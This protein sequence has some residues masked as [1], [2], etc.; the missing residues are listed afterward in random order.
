[1][2]RKRMTI[3]CLAL[4]ALL[5]PPLAEAKVN[6]GDKVADFGLTDVRSGKEVSLRELT[7]Q[8]GV[9]VI[10]VAT[11]CPYSNAFNGVMADLAREYKARGVTVVGINPNQTEPA[12]AV[13]KHAED[14]GLDFVILKDDKQVI[15]DRLGATRTPEVFLLDRDMVVRY[16]GA[17][18]NSK[19]PTTK[20]DQANDEE[21]RPALDAIANGSPVAVAETKAFGCTIKR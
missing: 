6:V 5:L 8:Q 14:H 2:I 7:G 10:F 16:H 1:M 9:A 21:L 20:A 19:V 15:A 12:A 13:K 11:E 18:G 17:I 4:T 3:V